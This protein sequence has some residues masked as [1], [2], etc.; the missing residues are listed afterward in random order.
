M[1]VLIRV[2]YMRHSRQRHSCAMV[3]QMLEHIVCELQLTVMHVSEENI[4][5]IE[6][7]ETKMSASLLNN[8][9]F[10]KCE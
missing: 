1:C 8:V 10:T 5:I 9:L 2:A 4:I 7:A 3:G 6:R